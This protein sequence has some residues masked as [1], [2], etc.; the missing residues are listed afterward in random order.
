MSWELHFVTSKEY[1]CRIFPY[2]SKFIDLRIILWTYLRPTELLVWTDSLGFR[3]TEYPNWITRWNLQVYASIC[4]ICMD[5]GICSMCMDMQEY[6]IY[7]VHA[8]DADICSICRDMQYMQQ[9]AIN[10]WVCNICRSMC[11]LC[12][13]CKDL[14]GDAIYAVYARICSI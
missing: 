3:F 8:L 7:A 13:V 10:T 9:Y 5:A 14:Q 4:N 2:M 11:S 1:L 6:A 12:C